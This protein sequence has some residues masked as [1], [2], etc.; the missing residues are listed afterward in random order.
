LEARTFCNDIKPELDVEFLSIEHVIDKIERDDQITYVPFEKLDEYLAI[1]APTIIHFYDSAIEDLLNYQFALDNFKIVFTATSNEPV[2]HT[3]LADSLKYSLIHLSDHKNLVVVVHSLHAYQVLVAMGMRST[4]QIAPY[5]LAKEQENFNQRLSCIGFASSPLTE[6]S[7]TDKGIDVLKEVIL[8]NDDLKFLIAWRSSSVP[9]Y[10]LESLE[11]VELLYDLQNIDDFYAKIG[12]LL[13]PFANKKNHAAPFSCIEA[14]MRGIPVVVTDAVGIASFVQESGCGAVCVPEKMSVT[15]SI[16]TVLDKQH[17]FSKHK[18]V[19]DYFS[20]EKYIELMKEIYDDLLS[21]T[22]SISLNNWINELKQFE[23]DLIIRDCNLRNY[24][25][26]D[27]VVGDYFDKRFGQLKHLKSHKNQVEAVHAHIGQF[28]NKNGRRPNIIDLATGSG[29]F[30][31]A[32]LPHGPVTLVDSSLAMLYSVKDLLTS[33][34][35]I[36]PI[37]VVNADIFSLPFKKAFDVVVFF[38]ILRHLQFDERQKVYT[39]LHNLI[40][41]DGFVIVDVPSRA[42]ELAMREHHGWQNYNVY[43][44]IWDLEDFAKEIDM[45]GFKLQKAIP[46]GEQLSEH[47][48][49]IIGQPVEHLCFLFKS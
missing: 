13:I 1:T 2:D 34:S 9:T 25:K 15:E 49:E 3:K 27:D 30:L 29:R 24:Y 35:T 42:A 17:G 20:R 22:L 14:L 26:R 21:L 33:Q 44:C 37:S 40:E 32:L 10:G 41:T 4:V 19:K 46:I 38:R 12:C 39:I 45:F 36:Y 47:Y 5:V 31:E 16:R 8:H 7:F 18:L 11:N 23:K 6:D 43:D 48:K 28:V